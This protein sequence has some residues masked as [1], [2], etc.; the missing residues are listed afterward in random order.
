MLRLPEWTDSDYNAYVYTIAMFLILTAR[1]LT[2]TTEVA[3]SPLAVKIRNIVIV[4][5]G[6]KA[7]KMG[8]LHAH[9]G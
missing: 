5:S 8:N 1:G 6:A 2:E 7:V 3:V 9:I 4:H